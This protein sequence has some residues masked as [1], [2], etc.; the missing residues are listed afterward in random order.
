MSSGSGVFLVVLVNGSDLGFYY[1]WPLLGGVRRMR[2][3]G[4]SAPGQW[5]GSGVFRFFLG[6]VR[7]G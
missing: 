6:C 7:L 4:N 3:W 5:Q 1:G 2:A